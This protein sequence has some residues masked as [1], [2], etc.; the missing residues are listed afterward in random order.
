MSN[1]RK[2][3]AVFSAFVFLI[4]PVFLSA[5][6]EKENE[7]VFLSTV[8]PISSDRPV[9]VPTSHSEPEA[10]YKADT[11][12]ILNNKNTTIN[13]SGAT[14]KSGVLSVGK[15]G[16][17]Y[18][19]GNLLGRIDVTAEKGDV[20]LYLDGITVESAEDPALS[21]SLKNGEIHLTALKDTNNSF[22]S[23]A[24]GNDK[25][26]S[27]VFSAGNIT[28]D[29]N[30]SLA[31]VCRS[32][33][34][35]YSGGSV[36][37]KG[38]STD[39]QSAAASVLVNKNLKVTGGALAVSSGKTALIAKG[40][41][42]VL[43]LSGGKTN[44]SGIKGCLKSGSD[45]NISGGKHELIVGGGST[46]KISANQNNNRGS[47]PV[48]SSE[49]P[50]EYSRYS[51]AVD[52]GRNI[53]LS[54]GKIYVNSNAD[55]F[56]ASRV[57][58]VSGGELTVRSD[59]TAFSSEKTLSV[60]GGKTD[61]SY[62][63]KGIET[64]TIYFSD[65]KFSIAAKRRAVKA[66]KSLLQSGGTLVALSYND[67][68]ASAVDYGERCTIAAGTLFAAGGTE[69]LS[70]ADRRIASLSLDKEFT[71]GST[72]TVAL[73]DAAI[74]SSTV[75]FDCDGAILFSD[76]LTTGASYNIYASKA[77]SSDILLAKVT[78]K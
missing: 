51:E 13:G 66:E 29:G 6:T 4:L 22:T 67:K 25:N 54:G 57:I 76:V 19:K 11:Y 58:S 2:F 32:G 56:C 74:L 10:E 8:R 15:A 78:A 34:G 35:I 44:I 3:N 72:L 37:F 49:I 23:R 16:A 77:G 65:G 42:S 41:K 27:A 59:K 18:I 52:A 26:D 17:Y 36:T 20:H 40:D 46:G 70:K 28:V 61:I 73:N 21:C 24:D 14:F 69:N 63:S 5:C 64:E 12:I 68:N 33:V 50:A 48:G 1:F 9:T 39:I 55:A 38:A 47:F 31:V 45:V 62:C 71:G 60:S 75:P 7:Q 30:G 43:S 53:V